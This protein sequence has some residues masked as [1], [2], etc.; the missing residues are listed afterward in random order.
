MWKVLDHTADI[1]IECTAASWAELLAEPPRCLH[2]LVLEGP[3]AEPTS[4]ARAAAESTSRSIDVNGIDASETWVR[5]WRAC[6]RLLT[7]EG[8]LAIDARVDPASGERHA[9][10]ILACVPLA[11]LGPLQGVD[12]KAVTWHRAS[13]ARGPDGTWRGT[14]VLDV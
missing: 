3:R 4:P 6:L 12:I 5:W 8:L 13:A 14:I 1:R 7:V 9:Q 2:S 11:A 10:G